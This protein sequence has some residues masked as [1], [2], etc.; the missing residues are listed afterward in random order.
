MNREMAG[1]A[2]SEDPR[3]EAFRRAERA[4]LEAL[5]VDASERTVR[6]ERLG[7]T[8]R[9]LEVGEGPPVV[10]M[11]GGG[12]LG[13]GWA[14]L[15]P[16]LPGFRLILP[17]RPGFGL[18]ELV[19]YRDVDL[20]E[21][22]VAFLEDLFQA[23]ELQNASIVANS[24]GAL[25]SLWFTQRHPDRV[26]RLSL[27]GT[28]ALI[29]ETS[30][31][32]GMRLLGIPGL[33]RMMMALE[34]PSEK[35]VR[36]LWKRMGHDPA[37]CTPEMIELI[38]CLERLPNYTD[39]WLSLLENVLP[40]SRVNR[41]VSF[42]EADLQ[43]VPNPVLYIWGEKDPFGSL[44]AA[45]RADAATPDSRL[46]VVGVGHLPWLDEPERCGALTAEFFEREA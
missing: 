46:E 42:T 7:I 6:M 28:P 31:P 18:T 39:A 9:Y 25:W 33:N 19:D 10:M 27:L 20:R 11:H 13:A 16:Y 15:V 43:R 23:A 5:G 45:R 4:Y 40:F 8:G 29:L 14:P 1:I 37:V 34:P 26:G 35:Q 17:D 22:A 21:H 24:M 12:G 2:M 3:V 44:V 41:S 30:A 32:G 38:T 36:T